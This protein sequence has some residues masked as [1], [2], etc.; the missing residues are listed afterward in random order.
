MKIIMSGKSSAKGR[1]GYYRLKGIEVTVIGSE[2]PIHIDFLSSKTLV[3]GIGAARVTLTEPDATALYYELGAR[4]G[5][6]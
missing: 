1:N 5:V 4:L 3:K 2:T 6:L